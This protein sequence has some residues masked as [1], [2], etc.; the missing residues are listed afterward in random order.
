MLLVWFSSGELSTQGPQELQDIEAHA[1][2]AASRRWKQA[3]KLW[4]SNTTYFENPAL[5]C[6]FSPFFFFF[7]VKGRE[8]NGKSLVEKKKKKLKN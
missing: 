8:Q 4:Y 5:V 6:S 3:I 7:S 1:G 2:M